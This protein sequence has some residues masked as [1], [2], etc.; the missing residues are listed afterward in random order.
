MCSTYFSVATG[1]HASSPGS[2]KAVV[3]RER[4][5]TASDVVIIT[6]ET[7]KDVVVSVV[8]RA[9]PVNAISILSL[10]A[11]RQYSPVAPARC[12]SSGKALMHIQSPLEALGFLTSDIPV[13]VELL[14]T[15]GPLCLH[16]RLATG[17]VFERLLG[18]A[19]VYM[20]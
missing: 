19:L 20:K 13:R 11:R 2:G 6:S 7:D 12:I 3:G 10:F 16:I 14:A 17:T 9:P 15:L 18:L 5:K 1:I 4:P 8:V